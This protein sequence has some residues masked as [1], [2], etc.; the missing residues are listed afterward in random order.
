M[1]EREGI[2]MKGT[3]WLSLYSI[4]QASHHYTLYLKEK[5]KAVQ[6]TLNAKNVDG[7]LLKRV[8]VHGLHRD[9][10]ISIVQKIINVVHAKY[11]RGEI[12]TPTYK[13]TIITGKGKHSL[14]NTPVLL[15]SIKA[16][17]VIS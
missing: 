2:T 17:L 6:Q 14:N 8:D 16:Y 1:R 10:A 13:L 12:T 4:D 9:E 11:E 7:M 3:R 5:E 15:N